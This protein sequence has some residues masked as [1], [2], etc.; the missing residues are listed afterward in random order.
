MPKEDSEPSYSLLN[1]SDLDHS[2]TLPTVNIEEVPEIKVFVNNEEDIDNWID[3]ASM[4]ISTNKS[5]PDQYKIVKLRTKVHGV[6]Y[7]AFKRL[8]KEHSN[9][10]SGE[11]LE[12]NW[13]LVWEGM[14]QQQQQASE[15]WRAYDKR[16]TR[17]MVVVFLSIIILI[18]MIGL[19]VMLFDSKKK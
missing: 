3:L 6:V 2:S 17:R 10:D 8:L 16:M 4:Y 15:E 18:L 14:Q 11:D 9:V 1:F 7:V 19:L 5:L 13:N 12:V